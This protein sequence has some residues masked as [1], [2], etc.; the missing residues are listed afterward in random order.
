MSCI[1]RW[2]I[3]RLAVRMMAFLITIGLLCL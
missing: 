1:L 2:R 3:K